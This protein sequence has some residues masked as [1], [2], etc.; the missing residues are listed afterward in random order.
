MRNTSTAKTLREFSLW[1]DWVGREVTGREKAAI[2]RRP[3]R[4]LSY[5]LFVKAQNLALQ[6]E[7]KGPLLSYVST[8]FKYA[9]L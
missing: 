4:K 7:V 2:M 6:S 5:G 1:S 3:D 9:L 8:L